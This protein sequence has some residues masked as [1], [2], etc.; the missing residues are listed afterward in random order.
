[1]TSKNLIEIEKLLN[2]TLKF[3]KNIETCETA[4]T[5]FKHVSGFQMYPS[6]SSRAQQ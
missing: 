1:M 3:R 2:E 5:Q 4:K 6:A